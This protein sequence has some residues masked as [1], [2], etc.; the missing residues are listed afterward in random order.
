MSL[1][2]HYFYSPTVNELLSDRQL[3]TQMLR[4]EAALATAQ[5]QE[6]IVEKQ[7]AQM[8]AHFCNIDFIDLEKLSIEVKLGGNVAIP[9]VK[10]LARIVK[11]HDA[12]AAK[13]VHF[14]AT[15]Q[16]V[17]D[18]ATALQIK[19]YGRWL[20]SKIDDLINT[21][22]LLTQKHKGTLMIGRTL[23]QQ[24][25]PI[26]LGLKTAKW[27]STL[28][29]LKSTLIAAQNHTLT[30]RLGGAVGS[31]NDKINQ[32]VA[33]LM[34]AQLELKPTAIPDATDFAV[35]ACQLGVLN[36]WL[37]K[38]AK[39]IALMMQTEIG[40]VLEG[41]AEGKGGSSTMPHKRNPVTSTAIMANSA[42]IPQLVATML[43]TIPQEHERSAGLWHAQW[44]TLTE[45][46][47]L[48]AGSIERSVEL[49]ESLEIDTERMAQNLEL[50]RGL[51]Y[52]EE[53]SL[54]L[55]PK[56]GK[57]QAHEL[58]EKACKIA[59]SEKKHLKEVLKELEIELPSLDNLFKPDNAIGRCNEIIDEILH[60]FRNET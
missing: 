5:A 18:T 15:S 55:A 16:D 2:T 29:H 10:N 54:A 50:T 19:E 47:Q 30:L 1:Y 37:G 31:G 14:G 11:N 13:Y 25:R 35:Y 27:L 51:I 45:L 20:A 56:I 3:I 38:I 22:V 21:L 9:F 24:A 4:F 39:D 32:R 44:E 34:A 7:Y 23:L 52:A 17:I 48:T 46:M 12:E 6:G 42:R 36:Q 57:T 59:I 33:S 53:V 26:T 49:L 28:T 8:I 58:V 40:E 43:T 60:S 41:A